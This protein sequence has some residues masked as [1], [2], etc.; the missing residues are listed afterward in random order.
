MA[1]NVMIRKICRRISMVMNS[2]FW[3]SDSLIRWCWLAIS[4][5]GRSQVVSISR[6]V[7]RESEKNTR[8]GFRLLSVNWLSRGRLSR[9][10]IRL[11]I[12]G[13]IQIMVGFDNH[14]RGISIVVGRIIFSIV[15]G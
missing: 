6:G 15:V 11:Y 1:V 5:S 4:I 9:L 2:F 14:T 12:V 13:L 3:F 10:I 7:D 8:E